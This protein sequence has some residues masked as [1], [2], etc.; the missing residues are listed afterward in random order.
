MV[1]EDSYGCTHRDTVEIA[2]Q[3][4]LPGPNVIDCISG[5][6]GVAEIVWDPVGGCLLYTSPSPRDRG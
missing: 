1:V 5:E 2:V 6:N 4:Q 3:Q